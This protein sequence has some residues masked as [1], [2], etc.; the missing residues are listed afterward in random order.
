MHNG[1]SGSNGRNP[2]GT[3]GQDITRRPLNQTT[4]PGRKPSRTL[5]KCQ[6]LMRNLHGGVG[7]GHPQVSYSQTKDYSIKKVSGGDDHTPKKILRVGG[8]ENFAILQ[9]GG[10]EN[11]VILR[12]GGKVRPP[13]VTMYGENSV[14]GW[15][16]KELQFCGW[17]V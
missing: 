8:P 13:Q 15:S 14:G 2:T 4:K 3:S 1:T 5:L 17:V 16:K 6:G 12:V 11:F 10:P 9:V 7:R